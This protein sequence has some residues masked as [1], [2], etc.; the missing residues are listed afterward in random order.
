MRQKTLPQ[1]LFTEYADEL[2]RFLVWKVGED[3]AAD[4]LQ[5]VYLHMVEQADLDA[6]RQPRAFLFR[7]AVN[8]TT[9]FYRRRHIRAR[10]DGPL[11]DPEHTATHRPGPE[12]EVAA[13]LRLQ[14]FRV[15]LADL[16]PLCRHAFLLNRIEGLSHADIAQRLGISK[17][18][19][20]RHIQRAL[21]HCLEARDE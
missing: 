2:H 14:R 11:P 20:E 1:D 9:D 5:E 3:D 18:T 17:K 21:R 12:A 13:Q 8:L 15:L 4:L 6:I 7:I 16:P 10:H 19:V